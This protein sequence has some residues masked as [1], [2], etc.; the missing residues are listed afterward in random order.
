MI[1]IDKET[2]HI[3]L[4]HHTSVHHIQGVKQELKVQINLYCAVVALW[5]YLRGERADPKGSS[6][7]K[8]RIELRPWKEEFWGMSNMWI[9]MCLRI[10]EYPTGAQSSV[11]LMHFSS[12]SI[13]TRLVV[14]WASGAEFT[15]SSASTYD[16]WHHLEEQVEMEAAN[17]SS[18]LNERIDSKSSRNLFPASYLRLEGSNALP[19]AI[20]LGVGTKFWGNFM[21]PHETRKDSRSQVFS[22]VSKCCSCGPRSN[23]SGGALWHSDLGVVYIT[24]DW[25]GK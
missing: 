18:W 12:I 23:Q 5:H 21:G 10:W 6:G 8:S 25:E 15:L 14:R 1:V 24:R 4:G 22:W 16:M 7:W 17:R 3:C 13:P 9:Q 19:R 2:G 20:S 11:I